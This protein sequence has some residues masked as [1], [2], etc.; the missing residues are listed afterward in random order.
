[1][2]N[3]HLSALVVLAFA[4]AA[5]AGIITTTPN[6]MGGNRLY[7]GNLS[8]NTTGGTTSSTGGVQFNGPPR[9]APPPGSVQAATV[10]VE[11]VMEFSINGLPPGEPILSPPSTAS[12]LDVFV[13][14][15][16]VSG[17]LRYDSELGDMEFIFSR[18]ESGALKFRESPTLPSLGRYAITNLGG[19][20]YEIDS[21]F[22]IF[23]EL[24]LDGGATWTPSD[25]PS[26]FTLVPAPGAA[27]LLG[28]GG[29]AWMRRRR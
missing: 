6:V 12:F 1:M 10:E 25:G 17:A 26:R 21:F 28:L 15:D 9:F 2:R 29:L 4:G 19:G 5:Q 13:D 8:W 7:V 23:T 3:V 14:I 20:L 24:S 16:P 27:A 11:A 18:A 22:D